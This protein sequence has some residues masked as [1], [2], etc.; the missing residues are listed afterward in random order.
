MSSRNAYLSPEQ[1]RNA[2]TLPRAMRDALVAI[3]A[4]TPVGEAL[5]TLRTTLLANGFDS[6]DYADLRN[7]DTLEALDRPGGNAR[8]FVAARIGGTR[9][10]DN[11]P[12]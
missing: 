10:I 7:A 8:L 9:L 6:V 12:V 4:G 11:M 5:D 1:R 3:A 2:A